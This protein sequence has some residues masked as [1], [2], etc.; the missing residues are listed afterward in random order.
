MGAMMP[1]NTSAQSVSPALDRRGFGPEDDSEARMQAV[2]SLSAGDLV[3]IPGHVMMVIG[4]I[5]GEPWVIHDTTGISYR[6]EEGEMVRVPLNAVSVTPLLPLQFNQ[7]ESY[8]DRMTS[9]V[10]I[11]PGPAKEAPPSL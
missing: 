4:T 2:R 7:T 6:S 5:G 8:V 3:Y 1:R 10:K 9:I 11:V